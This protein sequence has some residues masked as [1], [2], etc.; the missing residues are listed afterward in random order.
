MGIHNVHT[1]LKVMYA[2][3]QILK[4]TLRQCNAKLVVLSQNVG[5][6]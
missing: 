2:M 6:S 1:S 3:A 4:Q 5:T